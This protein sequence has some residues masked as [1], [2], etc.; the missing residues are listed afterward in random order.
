[1]RSMRRMAT[2][3]NRKFVTATVRDV[4]VGLL[5]P[6]MAK[7]VAEKYMREFCQVSKVNKM[8]TTQNHTTYKSTQL[9]Q[10]LQ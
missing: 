4:S 10:S 7:I 1:M 8:S 9:L 5:K 2:I 3:V 6:T